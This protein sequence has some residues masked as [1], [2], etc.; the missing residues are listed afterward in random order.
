MISCPSGWH[1]KGA[2]TELSNSEGFFGLPCNPQFI[3]CTQCLVIECSRVTGFRRHGKQVKNAE[4]GELVP[5]AKS[6]YL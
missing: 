5:N 3:F 4:M 6:G 2:E 1:Q